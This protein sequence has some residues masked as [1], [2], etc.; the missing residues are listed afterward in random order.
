ML[1][2]FDHVTTDTTLSDFSLEIRLEGTVVILDPSEE[3]S[4]SILS[5]LVGLDKVLAGEIRIDGQEFNRYFEDKDLPK[6]FGYIFDK[7]IMLSNL[8]LRENLL[9]PYRWFNPGER[10]LKDFERELVQWLQ[11]FELKID[12][13]QRPSVFK[14][15]ILKMVS[16]IR[17]LMLKPKILVIDDPYYILNKTERCVIRRVLSQL[18]QTQTMLIASA[19]DDFCPPF[20]GELIDLSPSV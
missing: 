12:L 7:G 17:T 3:L 16:Y 20:A 11:A 14:P 8:S 19:D 1:I 18:Q 10:K 2:E 13:D 4:R 5:T 6:V 9:L 15:A